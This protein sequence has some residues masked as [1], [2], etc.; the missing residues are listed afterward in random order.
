MQ[1]L[2]R[3]EVG[4]LIGDREKEFRADLIEAARYVRIDLKALEADAQVRAFD[5]AI[6]MREA[7]P[8]ADHDKMDKLLN[9]VWPPLYQKLLAEIQN[10]KPKAQSIHDVL[11]EMDPI[12]KWFYQRSLEL[13]RQLA[14]D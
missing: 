12:N 3:R 7:F 2:A 9:D 8:E 1:R 14:G 5:R 10:D 13:L 6:E 4:P 11:V